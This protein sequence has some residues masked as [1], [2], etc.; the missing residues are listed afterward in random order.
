MLKKSKP[1]KVYN[2]E[3]QP[4]QQRLINDAAVHAI[5]SIGNVTSKQVLRLVYLLI[6][7][8]VVCYVMFRK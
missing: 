3:K 4:K 7:N 1:Q 8:I 6:P 2:L 5:S